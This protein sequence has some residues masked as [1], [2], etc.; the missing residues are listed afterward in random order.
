MN[1][2]SHPKNNEKYLFLA[3]PKLFVCQVRSNGIENVSEEVR[4]CCLIVFN[5]HTFL[6]NCSFYNRTLSNSRWARGLISYV[7][8]V[9][10]KRANIFKVI[11]TCIFPLNSHQRVRRPCTLVC[12]TLWVVQSPRIVP[13]I[14]E[15]LKRKENSNQ[16]RFAMNRH[17]F[18]YYGAIL[19]ALSL[20]EAGKDEVGKQ[21]RIFFELDFS[22][23]QF[24]KTAQKFEKSTDSRFRKS[25]NRSQIAITM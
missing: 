18:Y 13:P 9:I 20:V 15:Q 11:E 12:C 25:E 3:S 14:S 6:E 19:F 21:V 1:G 16:N 17:L 23:D 24:W 5:E 22:D 8:I 2:T 4:R 7:K 10:S